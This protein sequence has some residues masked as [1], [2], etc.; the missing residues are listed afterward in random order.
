MRVLILENMIRFVF[1]TQLEAEAHHYISE[2]QLTKAQVSRVYPYLNQYA[3]DV[4][5]GEGK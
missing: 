3:Y 4:A 5:L 1:R 2:T